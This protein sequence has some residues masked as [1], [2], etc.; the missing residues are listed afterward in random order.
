MASPQK[1]Y[2]S[3]TSH[4]DM[5]NIMGKYTNTCNKFMLLLLAS[6]AKPE[7]FLPNQIRTSVYLHH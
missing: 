7:S 2:Y 6:K 1:S 4:K 5:V 3:K